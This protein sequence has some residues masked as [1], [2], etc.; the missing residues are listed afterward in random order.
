MVRSVTQDICATPPRLATFIQYNQTAARATP[1]QVGGRSRVG[2][3]RA[4]PAAAS[5]GARRGIKRERAWEQ[6]ALCGERG[7]VFPVVQALDDLDHVL[8]QGSGISRAGEFA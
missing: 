6:V 2:S 7:K 1:V 8:D 4:R 5:V 3:L